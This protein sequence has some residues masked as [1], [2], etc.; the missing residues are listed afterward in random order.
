MTEN[1]EDIGGNLEQRVF[2]V[3]MTTK[4]KHDIILPVSSF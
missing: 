1:E 4:Q 2:R 3:A